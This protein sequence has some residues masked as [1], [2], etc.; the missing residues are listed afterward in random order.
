MLLDSLLWIKVVVGNVPIP[1]FATWAYS[2]SAEAPVGTSYNFCSPGETGT[3][4]DI[5]LL[6]GAIAILSQC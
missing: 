5:N 1:T 4:I 6:T 2:I 3:A